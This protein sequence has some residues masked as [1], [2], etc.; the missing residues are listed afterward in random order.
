MT[1]EGFWKGVLLVPP[2]VGDYVL[3]PKRK[4]QA[5][6]TH[7]KSSRES[8]LFIGIICSCAIQAKLPM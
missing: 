2:F 1:N 6:R 8:I 7:P 4:T 5:D 3:G